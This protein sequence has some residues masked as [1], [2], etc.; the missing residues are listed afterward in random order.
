MAVGPLRRYS[1]ATDAKRLKFILKIVNIHQESHGSVSSRLQE[2]VGKKGS[3]VLCSQS[4]HGENPFSDRLLKRP[5]LRAHSLPGRKRGWASNLAG[6][7]RERGYSNRYFELV[8][9]FPAG[10]RMSGFR[11]VTNNFKIRLYSSAQLSS[12]SKPWSST[13]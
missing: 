12:R 3:V 13:G 9:L 1:K 4:L 6:K 11:F 5:R 8:R 7:P 2:S 10:T